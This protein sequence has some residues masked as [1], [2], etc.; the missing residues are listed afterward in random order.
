MV[1]AIIDGIWSLVAMAL[2]LF[3]LYRLHQMKPK[4]PTDPLDPVNSRQSLRTGEYREAEPP[5][6]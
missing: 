2:T 5:N 3:I 4:A 1:G 6:C